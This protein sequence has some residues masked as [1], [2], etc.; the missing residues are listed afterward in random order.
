M[1]RDEPPLA[2]SRLFRK[3]LLFGAAQIQTKKDP[4]F[5]GMSQGSFLYYEYKELEG[6]QGDNLFSLGAFL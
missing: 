2:V 5:G 6:C 4:I 3:E 1:S